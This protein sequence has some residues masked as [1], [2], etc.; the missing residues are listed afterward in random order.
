MLKRSIF[1]TD[2]YMPIYFVS[3][4]ILKF[5]IA[6]L[7]LSALIVSYLIAKHVRFFVVHFTI[8]LLFD[9]L[10]SYHEASGISVVYFKLVIYL[11]THSVTCKTYPSQILTV[12]EGAIKREYLA[13][14][15][16]TTS[17]LLGSFTSSGCPTNDFVG[18][19]RIPVLPW[20][21]CTTAA[22]ALRLMELDAC[23][24]YTLQQKMESEKDKRI[25]IVLVSILLLV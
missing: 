17:E 3:L 21:P 6:A 18:A 5:I 15:Y 14:K 24:F 2:G 25:G 1:L 13:S 4:N 22:V 12:L 23:T 20:V 11:F 8:F 16:E 9:L 10:Y 19:E 7:L